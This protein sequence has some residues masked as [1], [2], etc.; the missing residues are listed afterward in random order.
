MGSG[1]SKKK[2]PKPTKPS[3]PGHKMRGQDSLL[4]NKQRLLKKKKDKS[5]DKY[6]RDELN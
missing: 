4:A 1:N 3:K 5:N 2:K 6:S